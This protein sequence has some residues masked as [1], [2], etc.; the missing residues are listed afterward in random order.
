[1]SKQTEAAQDAEAALP[2]LPRYSSA[3]SSSLGPELAEHTFTLEDSK[4]RPWVWLTVKSRAKGGR[5]WPLFYERDIISG[6]VA[7]DFD[8]TD[9]A[10]GV[11]VS[12]STPLHVCAPC[13]FAQLMGSAQVT[14]GVTAVG[15]EELTFMTVSQD[16]WDSKASGKP[17]KGKVT[18]P[19]ALSLPGEASVAA[20]PKAKAE[21]YRL[22]PTF[23]GK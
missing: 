17:P 7:V 14:A 20:K 9:G 16:L 23:T 12:V 5:T 4:G 6:T 19:F 11:A 2:A 8:R 15:Q 10:K 22:P 21:Y 18:Y 13:R 3:S 1:M